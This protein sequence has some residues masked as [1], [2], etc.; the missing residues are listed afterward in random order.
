MAEETIIKVKE[1][2]N[3][4]FIQN[5]L[6]KSENDQSIKINE[7]VIK[8]ATNK[9][10]NYTS[11]MFR[12]IVDYNRIEGKKII[13]EQKPII[14]KFEPIEEGMHKEMVNNFKLH[15]KIVSN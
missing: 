3:N 6:R 8:T 7:L 1:M 4:D 14:I 12:V 9:G 5:V 2:I 15:Q 11:D 13:N 10:D